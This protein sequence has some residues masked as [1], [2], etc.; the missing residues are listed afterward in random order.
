MN[1]PAQHAVDPGF[2]PVLA[3]DEFRDQPITGIAECGGQPYYFERLFDYDNDVYSRTFVLTPLDTATLEASLERH[4]LHARWYAA[5]QAGQI[6]LITHPT[7]PE[8]RDRYTQLKKQCD[9]AIASADA[10]SIQRTGNMVP[11][12]A[13]PHNGRHQAPWQVSWS[14][15]T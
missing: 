13:Q 12:G 10:R 11:L 5:F 14:D 6:K 15:A 1:A 7:F 4:R 3:I 2:E 9:E 8:D